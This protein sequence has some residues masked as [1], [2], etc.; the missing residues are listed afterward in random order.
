[1]ALVGLSSSNG[2]TASRDE[3]CKDH[4]QTTI[5]NF[6]QNTNIQKT[7]E[8]IIELRRY[9]EAAFPLIIK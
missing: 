3:A 1:M 8:I 2:E 5:S 4:A 6:I 7:K 9:R